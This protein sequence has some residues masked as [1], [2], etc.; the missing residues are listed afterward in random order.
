MLRHV[1]DAEALVVGLALSEPQACMAF[2]TSSDLFLKAS[3]NRDSDLS[4]KR[5]LGLLLAHHMLWRKIMFLDDDV[6]RIGEVDLLRV[7]RQLDR[8]PIAGFLM[9]RYPDNSVVCHANRLVGAPQ[10]VFLSGAALGINCAR[11][12]SFFPDIYN[13]DWF[14]FSQQAQQRSLVQVGVVTQ[15][16][17]DP[18]ENPRRAAQEEFGDV[19][20]EGLFSLFQVGCQLEHADT[21]FWASFLE[22]RLQLIE[23]IT[24]KL[25]GLGSTTANRVLDSIQVA[26]D[27]HMYFDPSLCAEYLLAWRQDQ[28][29]WRNTLRRLKPARSFAAALDSS[30]I[31]EWYFLS[32]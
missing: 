17:F 14:F 8:S 5:N 1:P 27:Q 18:F 7:S 28:K 3:A 26:R 29:L 32:P 21:S 10:D 30:G 15:D 6:A 23:G 24:T 13:E 4:V 16:A 22:V 25:H 11:D 31:R 12:P 19:L 2:M 9:R 20:A